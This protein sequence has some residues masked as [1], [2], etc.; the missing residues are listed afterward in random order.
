MDEVV[1]DAA[2]R[3]AAGV[4]ETEIRGS[5]FT[6]SHKRGEGARLSLAAP[7]KSV[8]DATGR[9]ADMEFSID[10]STAQQGAEKVRGCLIRWREQFDLSRFEYTQHVR[11]APNEIP[12]SH[13]VLT[14]NTQLFNPAE[15]LSE[16][17]HEQMHWYAT[18]FGIN[19]QSPVILELGRRYPNA[20]AEFPEGASDRDSTILH[21]LIN[22]LEIEAVSAFLPRQQAEDIARR[23]RYYRWIY[24]T[25][26]T[27]WRPLES[28]F[29]E[30][31]IMP[32]IH[33]NDM[34]GR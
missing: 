3:G 33:A 6:S 12:H 19:E 28:L 17:L 18:G 22:W 14:L 1:P 34:A 29:R 31:G 21:L 32:I 8:F 24:Q 10:L 30:H 11:I 20:P 23:K 26:L 25:V 4:G 9:G 7:H 16:Y 13:P 15:I 27:D 5:F 2:R